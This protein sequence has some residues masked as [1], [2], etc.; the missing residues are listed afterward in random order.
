MTTG[1]LHSVPREFLGVNRF[2]QALATYD[3]HLA[4]C[5]A[6]DAGFGVPELECAWRS[7]LARQTALASTFLGLKPAD[8]TDDANRLG[9]LLAAD[10]HDA[11]D[12][13]AEILLALLGYL[14]A[15][16]TQDQTPKTT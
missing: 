5:A 9:V 4:Q 14:E 15:I 11:S 1:R 3:H 16:A 6:V 8:T 10:D 13:T 12:A 2:T 7:I